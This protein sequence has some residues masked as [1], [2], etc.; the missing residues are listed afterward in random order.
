MFKS[1]GG[2]TLPSHSFTMPP[3]KLRMLHYTMPPSKLRMLRY[4]MPPFK[5]RMLRYTLHSAE[6]HA[7]WALYPD[8]ISLDPS[9]NQDEE[10]EVVAS[11]SG[12]AAGI[13]MKVQT[14]ETNH[15]T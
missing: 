4:T 6:V 3:S 11:D 10:W 13:C 12:D 15:G 1:T 2:V 5:L 14:Y 8:S 7:S 9:S